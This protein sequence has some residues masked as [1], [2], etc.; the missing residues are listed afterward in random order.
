[1]RSIVPHVTSRRGEH[2]AA[3]RVALLLPAT[4]SGGGCGEDEVGPLRAS[5]LFGG[6]PA[7]VGA[8]DVGMRSSKCEGIGPDARGARDGDGLRKRQGV[9]GGSWPAVQEAEKG[10]LRVSG[11][12]RMGRVGAATPAHHYP[13]RR[14]RYGGADSGVVGGQLAFWCEG[15]ESL[16]AYPKRAGV[17]ALRVQGHQGRRCAAP[18]GLPGQAVHRFTR[19]SGPPVGRALEGRTR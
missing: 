10:W 14:G 9:D 5:P 8:E 4:A 1:M 6:V 17:R 13:F 15:G 12:E 16:R 18:A 7:E 3:G 2:V 11:G 19:L